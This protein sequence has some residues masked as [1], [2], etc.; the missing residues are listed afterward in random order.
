M[1]DQAYRLSYALTI[2]KPK[3]PTALTPN[4][5]LADT[6]LVLSVVG[7]PGGPGPLSIMPMVLGPDGAEGLSPV[8]AH[9]AATALLSRIEF[10]GSRLGESA[11]AALEDLRKAVV[12]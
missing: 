7:T 2:G 3:P 4:E 10:D 11:R 8:L 12:R 6:L 5:G 1:S 9:M